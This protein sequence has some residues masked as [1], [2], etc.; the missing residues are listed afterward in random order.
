VISGQSFFSKG[1]RQNSPSHRPSLGLLALN[2]L[3][4]ATDNGM[5][6]VE[7][8]LPCLE[9][10]QLV[11]IP[12]SEG[13]DQL[14]PQARCDRLSTPRQLTPLILLAFMLHCLPPHI[15]Q[16]AVPINCALTLTDR[17][18]LCYI[19]IDKQTDW[20]SVCLQLV[21]HLA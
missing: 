14:D 15:G 19:G 8:A 1:Q 17:L 3:K 12:V 5:A 21:H 2:R 10:E 13:R 7:F 18:N 11:S 16:Y 6:N 20:N 4:A 9:D